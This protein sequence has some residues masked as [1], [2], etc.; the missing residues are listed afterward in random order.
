MAET[1]ATVLT[2]DNLAVSFC[3]DKGRRPDVRAVES[4]SFAVG[5]GEIVAIV[6]ES[7]SGKSV[8]SLAL[9]GLLPRN[10]VV[11]GTALLGGRDLLAM[12][13]GELSTVRG[14]QIAMVFQDPIGALDPVFTIG[15]Q[16]KEVLRRH[17]P[18]MTRQQRQ[19]KA[20][21][22]L[23]MVELPDPESRLGFFPHQL[24][25]GQCQRVMIAMAL[26][27]D[28]E[29]LIADEPTTAL[30]VTVQA[31]VL[32]V[33][34]RLRDRTQAAIILITHDMGVV[35]DIADRVVVMRSG[36][37]VE[38]AP[39][40]DLFARPTA[41]YTRELLAAVPKI[42]GAER[43]SQARDGV[44]LDVKDLVVEY[45]SKRRAKVRAVDGVSFSIAPGE[46]LGL[47]GES[48]S[49]KSTIGR[50]VLGLAP[51]SGGEIS[52]QGV[53]LAAASGAARRE[54]LKRIGV[55]FQN[56]L[57]SMN[58]RYTVGQSVAEPLA[59]HAGLRGAELE[60]RVGKLLEDVELPAA[61]AYRYPYELSG[62]QRQRVAIARALSLGPDLLIADEPTSALDVSVQAT[63]LGL[64]RRLQEEHQFAC[65]FISHDLAVIDELTDR[66][67]VM[68][69]GKLVEIGDR[70]SVLLSPAEGYTKRL[71]SAAPI[72]DPV[73]QRARRLAS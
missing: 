16:L 22:L 49:G 61:W 34:R 59:V 55:V 65:L 33:M 9:M 4:L 41:A 35:A 58:P 19:A 62:G 17:K 38:E 36:K 44:V 1:N 12:S 69:G 57:G 31:E 71:L 11:S 37:M 73:A 25:G 39:V 18:E 67:A 5:A 30:D 15:Y 8:S 70:R 21:E 14:K 28:P 42:N 48:G 24:S 66:V 23:Q 43:E 50:C 40:I 2:V 46:M 29:V 56:P 3:I 45:A 54:T 47:V 32:D 26:A 63:V 7:G 64:F 68:Q 27:C 20:L 51:V 52:V 72:A 53:S 13:Q 6:G 60:N 10:A